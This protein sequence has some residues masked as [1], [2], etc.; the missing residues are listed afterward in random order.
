[1]ENLP[2]EQRA[3]IE[4]AYFAG[5][6]HSEIAERTGRSTGNCKDEAAIG[7]GDAETKFAVGDGSNS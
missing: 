4:F 2:E 7:A 5:M 3:A 1:M 6:T